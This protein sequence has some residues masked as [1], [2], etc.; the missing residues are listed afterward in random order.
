MRLIDARIRAA[1]D[2]QTAVG[3]VQ[4]SLSASR[5]TVTFDGSALAVP[6]KVLAHASV[7]AGSR[8][9]LTRYGSEWVVVGAFGPPP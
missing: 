9:A 4:A 7:Q 6:V 3:T 2:R 1:R 5:A 8:V